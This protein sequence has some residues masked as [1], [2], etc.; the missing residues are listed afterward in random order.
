MAAQDVAEK[1]KANKTGYTYWKREIND[2]H[3]LPENKPEKID[4]ATAEQA[5]VTRTSS[6]GSS[7]NSAG[8]WE[9]KDMTAPAKA[10]L[11]EI[12]CDEGFFLIR[13]EN[14]SVKVSSAT[15]TGESQAY[16]IRG[17]P[18]LGFEFKAQLSWIGTFEGEDVNGELEV[19]DLDSSDMSGFVLRPTGTG[20]ASKK[21]ADV[22][23]AEAR[24]SIIAACEELSRRMLEAPPPAR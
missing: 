8:T 22:L 7:W 10:C 23:K 4:S 1:P 21:A 5:E 20:D 17:R 13:G 16:N 24:Q 12:V 2:A 18:R 11:Q 14:T 6:V 19:K 3:L 15:V 9:E